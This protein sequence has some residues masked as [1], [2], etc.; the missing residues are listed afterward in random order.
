MPY[1]VVLEP[2]AEGG[3]VAAVPLFPGCA[4]QGDTREDALAN[5]KEAILAYLQDSV[6]MGDPTPADDDTEI[7]EPEGDGEIVEVEIAF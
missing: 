1:Q 3:F 7:A 6:A 2:Q 5:I 4:S